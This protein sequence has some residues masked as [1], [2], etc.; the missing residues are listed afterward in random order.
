MGL[1]VEDPVVEGEVV[2]V[3]E[4]QV[5]IP[6]GDTQISNRPVQQHSWEMNI[7]SSLSSRYQAASGCSCQRLSSAAGSYRC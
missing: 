3:G 2:V 6:A 1:S 7:P 4:E 5:E